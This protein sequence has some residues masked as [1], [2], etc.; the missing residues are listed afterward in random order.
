MKSL[1]ALSLSVA[2]SLTACASGD[3][4][5]VQQAPQHDIQ[6]TLTEIVHRV[7]ETTLV[8]A[9]VVSVHKGASSWHVVSGGRAL[10]DKTAPTVDDHFRVGS[11]TKTMVATVALQLVEE[12]KIGLDDAVSEYLP[13]TPNGQ[14][15]TIRELLDMR[16]GLFSYT[17]DEDFNRTLD[18][19][20]GH[21]W[22]PEDLAELG[23][24]SKPY[25]KPNK[26]YRY[27]NTNTVVLA[28]ILQK[29]TAEDIGTLLRTRVFQPLQLR[30]TSFPGPDDVSLQSPFVHGYLY[31]TNSQARISPVLPPAQARAAKLGLIRPDDVTALNPSWIW[32]AGAVISTASDLAIYA[33]ALV[34]GTLLHDKNLQELRVASAHSTDPENPA[35]VPAYGLGL[36]AFGPLYGHDGAIPGYQSFMGYDP[37]TDTT[38][39]VLCDMRD[40]PTGVR[41]AN[42]IAKEIY[43]ALQPQ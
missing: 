24:S 16:S 6:T 35:A 18:D 33:K 5:P 27:T 30:Q 3:Q 36:M 2:V 10:D 42:E 43:G 26:G 7:R 29:I 25:F 37:A 12:G 31:G 23:E 8:P 14:N 19:D 22:D 28:L 4:A 39:I 11:I 34:Q 40:G 41:P 1:V 32:S 15:I 13:D 9:V 17:E 20:P 38:I 21:V